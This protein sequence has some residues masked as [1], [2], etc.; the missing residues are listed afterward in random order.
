MPPTP[1]V[2][3]SK[4][5]QPITANNFVAIQ[6][7]KLAVTDTSASK[8]FTA[9]PGQ[10]ERTTLKITNSGSN[11]CYLAAGKGS[12]TAVASSATPTPTTGEGMSTCDY[13]GPGAILTQ[14]YLAGYDTL[15]AICAAG[16]STTLE[17]SIGYGQ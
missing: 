10:T 13:I 3:K 16:L 11:G 9:V 5:S 17:I 4:L 1:P 12:A 15:A 8:T 2:Y 7:V 14:D 6:S